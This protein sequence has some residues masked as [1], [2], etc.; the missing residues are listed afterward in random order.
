MGSDEI[1]VWVWLF[2]IFGNVE[3]DLFLKTG[4]NIKSSSR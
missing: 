2:P 1:S 3:N 4:K